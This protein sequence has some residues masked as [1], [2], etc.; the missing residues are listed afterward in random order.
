[1]ALHR[2][3]RTVI[4]LLLGKTK[5]KEK[6]NTYTDVIFYKMCYQVNHIN[7]NVE[8]FFFLNPWQPSSETEFCQ[9]QN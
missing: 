7:N 4:C 2:L 6:P 1:M 8:V 5:N 3:K 9:S